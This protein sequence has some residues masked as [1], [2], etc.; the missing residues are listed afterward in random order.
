MDA[1]IM[2]IKNNKRYPDTLLNALASNDLY[3]SLLLEKLIKINKQN[4]FPDKYK[5]QVDVARSLLQSNFSNEKFA[6]IELVG[7]RQVNV[8]GSTGNVY[9]FKCKIKKEDDW[10]LGIAGLQPLNQHEVSA[11]REFV[12]MT[13]KKLK[14]SEPVMEQFDSQLKLLVFAKRKSAR[15]FAAGNSRNVFSG[16]NFEIGD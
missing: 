12:R 16:M 3:R 1:L 8:K 13:N 6:A 4:L 9:F 2:V 10:Q 5:T 15:Q 11:S 7:K 14:D